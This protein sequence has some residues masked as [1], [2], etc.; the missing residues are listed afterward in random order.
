LVEEPPLLAQVART[1]LEVCH[2]DSATGAERASAGSDGACARACYDCLLSYTNQPDHLRLDRHSVRDLLLELS[3]GS[4]EVIRQLRD[5][6]AHYDWLKPQVDE[7]SSL[8]REVLDTLYREGYRLPDHAQWRPTPQVACTP[9][10][11]FA[12][13]VC[14]FCDGPDHDD[15]RQRQVDARLR[16]KLEEL[17]YLVLVVRYD[18]P[19]GEQL[20]ELAS[21]YPSVFRE[22]EA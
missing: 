3:R 22:G 1:A 9:D 17:G 4:V 15:E 19:V 16:A 6:S 8:E 18:R 2:F 11:F 20:Q 5:R 14:L 7:R 10:F 13:N 21:R 12:P